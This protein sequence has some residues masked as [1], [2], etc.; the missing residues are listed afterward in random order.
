MHGFIGFYSRKPMQH[1]NFQKISRL[2]HY[3]KDN[4]NSMEEN[5]GNKKNGSWKI[6][7]GIAVFIA[8]II[9]NDYEQSLPANKQA[10]LERAQALSYSGVN[11]VHEGVLED[12]LKRNPED[13]AEC[14]ESATDAAE[15]SK[16]GF[17]QML[18]VNSR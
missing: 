4:D 2:L 8:L 1:S 13:D 9:K 16:K 6:W 7:I 15:K 12:C 10:R 5:N 11:M 3:M 17:D 14:Y 18:G